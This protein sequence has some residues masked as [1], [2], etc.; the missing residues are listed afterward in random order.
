MAKARW[1]RDRVGSGVVGAALRAGTVLAGAVTLGAMMVGCP[2]KPP[3]PPPAPPPVPAPAAKVIKDPAKVLEA[4]RGALGEAVALSYAAAVEGQGALKDKVDSYSAQVIAAKV[5]AEGGGWKLYLKGGCR[6]AD[7][8]TPPTEFE[9]GYDGST[10]RSLRPLEQAVYER[11]NVVEMDELAVFLGGQSVKPPVAWEL[12]S[13]VP[14]D[15]KGGT[16]TFE[17]QER[18]DG[19]L[20]DV[21]RISPPMHEASAAEGG[22]A[23]EA[24]TAEREAGLRVYVAEHDH[25]PRRIERLVTLAGVDGARVLRM[26]DLKVTTRERA[27]VSMV[28]FV[29]EAPSDFTHRTVQAALNKAVGG[30]A[31]PGPSDLDLAMEPL[32][33]GTPAPDWTLPTPDGSKVSLS[34]YAGKVVVLDFWGTWCPFCLKAMPQ[35]QKVHDAYKD[36]GVVVLGLN[37]ENDPSAD[38]AGFMRQKKYTY[39]LVLNA[40]KVTRPYRVFG[41]PTLYV[42]G[43]DGNIALVEQ[44]AKPD[45]YESVSRVIDEELGL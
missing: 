14:L 27:E 8:Q 9:I 11:D 19:M 13:E 26:D 36:R 29:L 23:G 33:V 5:Q 1:T 20:C 30:D 32:A 21:V 25:L 37:T 44:G 4:S 15:A 7:A 17:G 39:G 41:F 28:S 31:E 6:P 45:L 42:I 2:A 40:E 12:L 3:A 38:P 18:A 22:K 35:I 16:L 34:S 10:V 24:E 43:R